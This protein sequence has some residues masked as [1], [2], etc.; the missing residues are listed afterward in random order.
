MAVQPLHVGGHWQIVNVG[1]GGPNIAVVKFSFSESTR[2]FP[3]FTLQDLPVTGVSSSWDGLFRRLS[4]RAN[5]AF[6]LQGYKR[7]RIGAVG[8]PD[9]VRRFVGD[10]VFA[11]FLARTKGADPLHIAKHLWLLLAEFVLVEIEG[12]QPPR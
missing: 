4:G 9:W 5:R 10:I 7:L 11:S 1:W 2:S 3:H 8:A 6:G 12:R